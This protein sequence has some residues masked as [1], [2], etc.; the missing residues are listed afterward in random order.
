MANLEEKVNKVLFCFEQEKFEYD[1]KYYSL[2]SFINSYCYPE[3]D[4]GFYEKDLYSVF[5]NL[6]D[7][8]EQKVTVNYVLEYFDTISS[9]LVQVQEI[10]IYL[11]Q[12]VIDQIEK[13]LGCIDSAMEEFYPD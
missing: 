9:I 4:L 5:E 1:D 2:L 8:H 12:E 10:D 3:L 7:K 11:T 13:V 6:K